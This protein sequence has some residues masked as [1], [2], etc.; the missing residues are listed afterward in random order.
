MLIIIDHINRNNHED[1]QHK[2]ASQYL[3]AHDDDHIDNNPR[4]PQ[5]KLQRNLSEGCSNNEHLDKKIQYISHSH[6]VFM[7][8]FL[9]QGYKEKEEIIPKLSLNKYQDS[10][11]TTTSEIAAEEP[12]KKTKKCN[13]KQSKCLKLYCEC[14]AFGEFCDSSCGCVNCHNTHKD[15][16]VRDYA[17]SLI[18]ERNASNENS[19][20]IN[21]KFV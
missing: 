14:L 10:I 19:N 1:G 2:I 15:A 4:Q 16:D 13:C 18:L 5:N 11:I 17:L 8:S 6:E 21:V 7:N 9:S 20:Y 3:F 12:T